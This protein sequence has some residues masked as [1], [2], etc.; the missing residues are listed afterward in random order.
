[1]T[2]SLYVYDNAPLAARV[3]QRPA[4]RGLVEAGYDVAVGCSRGDGYLFADLPG[5]RVVEAP[6][7]G[8]LGGA[9]ADLRAWCPPDHAAVDLALE[10]YRDT[11]QPQWRSVATVL[12]RRL[13]A[14]GLPVCLDAERD[15]P[16]LQFEVAPPPWDLLRPAVLLETRRS[17]DAETWF[18]FDVE[19]LLAVLPD[20]AFLCTEPPPLSHDRLLDVSDRDLVQTA[21]LAERCEFLIGTTWQPF[22]VTLTERNRDKPK[23]V[24]GH[25]R[26]DHGTFWDYPG[27]P[28]EYLGTMDQ[29]AD[30]VRS[31]VSARSNPRRPRLRSA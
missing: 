25:D 12:N 31:Q 11:R 1:M 30:F 28:L 19:R 27:N 22:A 9:L 2:A 21:L 14:L 29:L 26:H 23:A 10:G 20:H 7:P 18:V 3:I 16:L 4:L 24:C 13:R 5:I 15:A 6:L 8:H 17:H